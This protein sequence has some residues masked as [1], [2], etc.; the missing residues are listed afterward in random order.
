MGSYH[1]DDAFIEALLFEDG[2]SLLVDNYDTFIRVNPYATKK[3]L[4]NG[5]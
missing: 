5:A 1:N 2:H 4:F 3:N